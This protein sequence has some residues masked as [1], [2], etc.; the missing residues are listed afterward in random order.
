MAC[1]R[2]GRRCANAARRNGISGQVSRYLNTLG[3]WQTWQ[4]VERVEQI[5][6][7]LAGLT[8]AFFGVKGLLEGRPKPAGVM[9]A[10]IG[11][12]ATEHLTGSA[13]T[14]G[15]RL[16][17][18]G[19]PFGTYRGVILRRARRPSWEA[20]ALGLAQE[21]YHFFESG[22]TWLSRTV[23]FPGPEGR[24]LSV[25]RSL[26]FPRREYYFDRA[27][28]PQHAVDIVKG[29]LEPESLPGFIGSVNELEDASGV[30]N[31]K[32][33]FFAADWLL[34][35]PSERDVGSGGEGADYQALVRGDKPGGGSGPQKIEVKT[36]GGSPGPQVIRSKPAWQ[37]GS[38]AYGSQYFRSGSSSG[39]PPP[40]P[41]PPPPWE[42]GSTAG[43]ATSDASGGTQTIR[44]DGRER[45]L[46][47]RRVVVNPITNRPRAEAAWYDESL[48]RW[49][50]V[51]DDDVREKLAEE[52]RAGR[53]RVDPDGWPV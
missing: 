52:V 45:P 19:E 38:S 36:G 39:S 46:V 20:R 50:L 15:M 49:R 41:P 29:D 22:R 16:F 12:H 3:N 32:R 37:S 23:S 47:I 21:D 10:V 33:L 35:D 26:S 13:L 34:V 9:A 40:P 48:G 24:S 51:D 17:G 7:R 6:E 42:P 27:L 44:V 25:L 14:F 11:L 31:L 53:L 4:D 8:A 2:N 30:G 5:P 43:A 28:A 18:R 1:D